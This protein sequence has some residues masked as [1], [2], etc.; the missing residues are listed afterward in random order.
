MLT[1]SLS[2]DLYKAYINPNAADG[3]LLQVARGTS[4]ICGCLGILL[5]IGLET[6]YAALVIFYTL[7][8]AA[9]LVPIIAGLYIRRL[10]ARTMLTSM[11]ASVATTFIVDLIS[12]DQGYTGIPPVIFG[13]IMGGVI[14]ISSKGTS[15]K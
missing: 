4:V 8:T 13:I 1:T 15:Q 2:K 7:L 12:K 14:I 10:T 11:M 9:L 5:A 3:R 6:V